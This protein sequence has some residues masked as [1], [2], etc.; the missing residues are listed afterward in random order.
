[1]PHSRR[2][3]IEMICSL[4]VPLFKIFSETLLEELLRD[5]VNDAVYSLKGLTCYYNYH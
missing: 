4:R 1:M 5:C 3:G 2:E